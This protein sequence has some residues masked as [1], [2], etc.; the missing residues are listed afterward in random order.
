MNDLPEHLRDVLHDVADRQGTVVALTGAGLSAE[1][2]IPTF[3]GAEGFWTVGSREYTPQ[4]MATWQMFSRQ[5]DLVWA[6]YL[7]RLS[8]CWHAEPN[9]GHRW[10]KRM[11]ERLEDRFHLIT[12]NV[13][14]LHA[15]VGHTRARMSE[16]HGNIR[17]L[18]CS[19]ECMSQ[20]WPM[21]ESLAGVTR[22]KSHRL[23]DE[24]RASLRCASCG[25]WARPHVLWFD[26]CYDDLYYDA[27]RALEKATQ[28]DLL[29]IV[30]TSGATSL[31]S[32]A[33]SRCVQAGGKLVEI[34]IERTAFS[35]WADRSG[36]GLLIG[37]ATR[38][39]RALAE[40]FDR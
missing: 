6:W 8:L 26:E 9:E 17:C 28:A 11:D 10:L 2:G 4:E 21:P 36:G 19:D 5:P 20:R 12:Q 13:D 32:I 33:A 1:S 38:W 39:L 22:T 23:T 3:R 30:G 27:S 29:L 15:A 37:S 34:N 25:Q 35:D 24:E 18:R 16:V 31:P 40:A 14:G 7:Y